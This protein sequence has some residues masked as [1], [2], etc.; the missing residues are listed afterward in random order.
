MRVGLIG[1]QHGLARH[2]ADAGLDV[3]VHPAGAPGRAGLD[4]PRVREIGDRPAFVALLEH[5]RLFLLDLPIGAAIDRAVDA[6]YVDMEPGD[7]V[8][9]PSGSYWGDTLRRYR[10]MRHRSLYYVDLALLGA[11]LGGAVLAGG[12]PRGVELAWPLLE[13]LAAP[14]GGVA[15]AGG[16]GAAHHALMVRDAVATSLAHA[17]SEARQLL[18]VYPNA[19]AAPGVVLGRL[20][21]AA[22]E[23]GPRAGW[24]LDDAVRLQAAVPH[25]AQGVMLEIGRAL[26][27][28]RPTEPAS[29]VGG[30]VGPEEIV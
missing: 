6:A 4:H 14:D 30:F 12:D 7:V 17:L 5:P 1:N 8:L 27:E 23:P 18:E 19:P 29:R 22:P 24:L 16:A 26:D 20:W 21:P 2:L 25:L 13:R 15:R 11:P 10:R 28:Q 3:V 9:D